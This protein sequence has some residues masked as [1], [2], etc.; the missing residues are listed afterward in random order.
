[1]SWIEPK[2]DW[3]SQDTFNFSDYNRIKNNIA[4][5]RERAVKLVKPFDIQDMGADMTSYAELFEAAKFNTLEQNLETINNNAYLKDYGT[6]Q[7]FY[8][9]GVFIA[10]AE[11]NRIESATLDIYNMLGRQEIGLRR[12]AFRLG[13]GREVRI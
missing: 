5:L 1:M 7:T 11:L 6:K 4:Y 13:A 3:T 2:T 10:Y 8:D 12:L 9:N